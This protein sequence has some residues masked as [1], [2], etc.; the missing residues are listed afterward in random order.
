[1]TTSTRRLG[2]T[3]GRWTAVVQTLPALEAECI[4]YSRALG[5]SEKT[6]SYY[7]DS[8]WLMDDDLDE[9]GYEPTSAVLTTRTFQGLSTYLRRTPTRK[10]RYS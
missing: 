3:S 5:R 10:F 8:F 1:M 6:I 4:I 7:Q 9:V 2:R